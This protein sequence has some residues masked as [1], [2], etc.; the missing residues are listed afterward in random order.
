MVT[1]KRENKWKIISEEGM[2]TPLTSHYPRPDTFGLVAGGYVLKPALRISETFRD[3]TNYHQSSM[4]VTPPLKMKK[5][6][7]PS[8]E[9]LNRRV[10]AFIKKVK[11]ER[12]ESLRLD[13]EVA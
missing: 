4:T 8:R 2:S 11:E 13:K 5:E 7:L 9:E 1:P 6:M 10:E 3:V 12:L